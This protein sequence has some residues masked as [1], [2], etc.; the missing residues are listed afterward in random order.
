MPFHIVV[1]FF[2]SVGAVI[3]SWWNRRNLRYLLQGLPS[4]FVFVGVVVVGV[5]CVFQDKALLAANYQTQ[6]KKSLAETQS[7]LTARRDASKTTAMAQTCYN[8]LTDL[9]PE[10]LENRYFLAKSF[11]QR[12]LEISIKGRS[13]SE[14]LKGVKDDAEKKSLEQ[15][16]DKLRDEM[17]AMDS[18]TLRLMSQLAPTDKRGF[19]LAHL[20]MFDRLYRFTPGSDGRPQPPSPLTIIQSEAHL[21]HA[22]EWPDA[23]VKGQAAFRMARLYR[24]TNRIDDAKRRLIEVA[25]QYPEYRLILAQWAKQQNENDLVQSHAKA[26]ENAFR[27]RLNGNTDDH[28]ARFGLVSCLLLQGKFT[29]ARDLLNEGGALATTPEIAQAYR[30]KMTEVLVSAYDAKETDSRSSIKERL[31]LLEGALKLDPD[32]PDLFN[33]L[34]KLAKDK[35][36]D[37]AKARESLHNMAGPQGG[38]WLAQL[39]L[40]IDAYQQENSAEAKYH[41]EKA[42][43]LSDSAPLVAN[44]LA[45]L[46]AFTPPP[47]LN[48]AL[49]LAELAV[50]KSPNEARYRGTR[51]HIYAKLGR[52]AEALEDLQSSIPAYPNDPNLF[53]VLS[54]VCT[55]L[56]YTKMAADY[57]KEAER[58]SGLSGTTLAPSIPGDKKP[59]D[60]SGE[61][62][63]APAPAASKSPDLENELKLANAAIEKSPGDVSAKVNRGRILAKLGR[64]KDAL[65]DLEEGYKAD[66]KDAGVLEAL[67]ETYTKLGNDT[68]AAQYKAKLADLRKP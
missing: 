42:L 30:R 43:A 19:G 15:E 9:Q 64:W 61:V 16:L 20:W 38:S 11:E 2:S 63:P 13:V 51:G 21:L 50:K 29:E 60:P 52:N 54:D 46:L 3:A 24:D 6:A 49:E 8:R 59:D 67:V 41:W 45:Y 1:L 28:E 32:N 26:A 68:K 12:A 23:G 39:Y 47:D 37:S 18:A 55:K 44:N 27:S 22:Y 5:F 25:N 10:N 7:L 65:P 56:N 35:S 40:G 34:L 57:R 36:P 53:K 66:P 58:L 33:R 14:K 17:N 48:R 4:L 62:K 31:D